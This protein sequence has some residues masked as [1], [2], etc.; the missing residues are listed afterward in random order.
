MFVG[1]WLELANFAI[2]VD[3]PTEEY[4]HLRLHVRRPSIYVPNEKHNPKEKRLKRRVSGTVSLA[5]RNV[6]SEN[7]R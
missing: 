4:F 2:R 6:S 3:L 5:R 7:D 1:G